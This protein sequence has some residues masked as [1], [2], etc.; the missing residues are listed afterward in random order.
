METQTEQEIK[1]L[2]IAFWFNS[3]KLKYKE[4]GN[5]NIFGNP[6][7]ELNLIKGTK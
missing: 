3:D 7:K 4:S 5:N 1:V 2:K 6:I